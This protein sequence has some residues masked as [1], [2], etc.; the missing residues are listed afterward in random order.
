MELPF[1]GEVGFPDGLK[2]D[3]HGNIWVSGP[4]GIWVVGADGRHLGSI[5]TP[6]IVANF[7]FGGP[8]GTWLFICASDSLLRL[9]TT[10]R[11]A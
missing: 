6:T 3:E 5:A 1:D 4:R 7:C 2:C 9:R 10:V 8:D 11:G